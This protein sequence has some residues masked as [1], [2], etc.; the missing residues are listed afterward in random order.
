MGKHKTEVFNLLGPLSVIDK[1]YLFYQKKL[2]KNSTL[3]KPK[4]NKKVQWMQKDTPVVLTL[5]VE[6]S[7]KTKKKIY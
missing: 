6:A 1:N 5:S 7:K 2:S 4:G 3:V